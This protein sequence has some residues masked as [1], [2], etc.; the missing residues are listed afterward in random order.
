MANDLTSSSQDDSEEAVS[1]EIGR[2]NISAFAQGLDKPGPEPGLQGA[3]RL[4]KANRISCL[5]ENLREHMYKKLLF[6]QVIIFISNQSFQTFI[7]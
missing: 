5:I 6:L 2:L 1:P 7:V 4:N 3:R